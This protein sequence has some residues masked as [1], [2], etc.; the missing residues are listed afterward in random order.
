MFRAGALELPSQLHRRGCVRGLDAWRLEKK[1]EMS[2]RLEL[3]LFLV[4]LA[5]PHRRTQ[6]QSLY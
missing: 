5:D 2:F 6:R 4:I 3:V 1:V